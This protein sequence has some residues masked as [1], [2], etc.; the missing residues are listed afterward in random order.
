MKAEQEMVVG[1]DTH[2]SCG[3]AELLQPGMTSIILVDKDTKKM[4]V[5]FCDL[6]RFGKYYGQLDPDSLAC[7]A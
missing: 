6:I 3:V 5:G 4:D 7:S 1:G 2:T